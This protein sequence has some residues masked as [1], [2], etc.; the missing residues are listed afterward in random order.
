MRAC[1]QGLPEDE[2]SNDSALILRTSRRWPLLIDPQQQA[3]VWLQARHAAAGLTTLRAT[4][5]ALL[6]TLESHVRAGTPVLITDVGEELGPDLDA[7][8]KQEPPRASSGSDASPK[9][10]KLRISG[11]DV[12]V[13]E[14]FQLY[15]TTQAAAPR[16]APEVFVRTS[17]LNFAV[18]RA[19]LTQQLLASTVRYERPALQQQK[20]AVVEQLAHDRAQLEAAQ[21]RILAS[22]EAAEGNIL[23]DD[24]L[25]A[26][27]D[28][29][30]ATAARIT[31]ALA[32]AEAT[33]TDIDAA[34]E[35]YIA[36]AERCALLYFAIAAL[37]VLDA[38]YHMALA[39][40]AALYERCLA[41][42]PASDD[43]Q[44]RSA[45]WFKRESDACWH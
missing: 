8:L 37:P 30:K 7:L 43:L 10:A 35:R 39:R 42:A 25:V 5:P 36:P 26:S 3:A 18:T 20:D 17:V 16:F 28:A 1:T 34:R 15:L 21:A 12:E 27:L 45:N 4:D 38:T 9:Q 13:A 24:E 19:A 23:D 33:E 40:F 6:A 31:A 32:A 2:A 29:S 41:Q 22:V 11:G 44:A 14:G